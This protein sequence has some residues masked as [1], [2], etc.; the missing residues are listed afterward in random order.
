MLQKWLESRK[1]LPSFLRDHSDIKQLFKCIHST[2]DITKSVQ[3]PPNW[4]DAHCYVIDVF[5]WH[6]AKHGYTLQRSRNK[7]LEF[8]DLQADLDLFQQSQFDLF[9]QE[10]SKRKSE[11][12]LSDYKSREI[13]PWI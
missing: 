8:K 2:V 4:I 1:Y 11:K 9:R 6:M 10:L 7:T 5:L 12:P 3:N 13:E